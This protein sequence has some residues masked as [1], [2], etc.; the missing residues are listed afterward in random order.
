MT[1]YIRTDLEKT[2]DEQEDCY[3]Y[4]LVL[5]IEVEDFVNNCT[6]QIEIPY[7]SNHTQEENHRMAAQSL[8]EIMQGCIG[9][10]IETEEDV[11]VH[12]FVAYR[13]QD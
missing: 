6:Q 5:A 4:T 13:R 12:S 2:Y 3:R 10:T 11:A 7:C 9:C 8:A 1:S